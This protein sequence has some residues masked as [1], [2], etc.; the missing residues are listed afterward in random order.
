MA[1]KKKTTAKATVDTTEYKPLS[2]C[3]LDKAPTVLFPKA[4]SFDELFASVAVRPI[5]DPGK[6]QVKPVKIGAGP[7]Q[8]TGFCDVTV[9]EANKHFDPLTIQPS[10]ALAAA[11]LDSM[12]Y[13]DHDTIHFEVIVYGDLSSRVYAKYSQI[14][15][16]R[17]VARF[18]AKATRA[19]FRKL[20]KEH[21]YTAL[22][23]V[24][25]AS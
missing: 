10:A 2:F 18:D 5:V 15:G 22:P 16:S 4:A 21:S 23:R 14:L 11:I 24:R 13:I 3:G 1:A 7:L 19:F 17:I 9:S 6:V 20:A 25:K 12:L 8:T